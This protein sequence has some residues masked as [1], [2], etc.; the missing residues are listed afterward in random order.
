MFFEFEAIFGKHEFVFNQSWMNY[1]ILLFFLF[2]IPE[3]FQI[4][5][6]RKDAQLSLKN[7]KEIYEV[8]VRI[9]LVY[10]FATLIS[11]M[12]KSET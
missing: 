1:N 8:L 11:T 7:K 6:K 12:Q 10:K 9:S 3:N 4:N 5:S 2:S